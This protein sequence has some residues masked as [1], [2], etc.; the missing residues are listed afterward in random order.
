LASTTF[1]WFAARRFTTC[2]N[3]LEQADAQLAPVVACDR[4]F[5]A[6]VDHRRLGHFIQV[7]ERDVLFDAVVQHQA[8]TFAVFGHVGDAV[9]IA[10]PMVL[11]SIGLPCSSTSPLMP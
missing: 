11:V 1:C 10:L 5:G 7:G 2:W 8:I 4:V 6:V 9:E 3:T